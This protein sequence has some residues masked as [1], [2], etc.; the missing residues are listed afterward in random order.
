[1]AERLKPVQ[2]LA[3][4]IDGSRSFRPYQDAHGSQWFEAQSLGHASGVSL[5]KEDDRC[6]HF[7]S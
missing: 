6:S 5:I 3:K 7:L 1:M 2:L 4:A